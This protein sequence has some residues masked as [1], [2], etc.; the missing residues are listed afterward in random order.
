MRMFTI[1]YRMSLFLMIIGC[2]SM[3]VYAQTQ[4]DNQ[5]M[6][7]T[8]LEEEEKDSN[9]EEIRRGIR[10]GGEG[11][12]SRRQIYYERIIKNI[13]PGLVGDPHKLK[14]YTDY[15]VQTLINDT[16]LFATD[17]NPEWNPETNT[18]TLKGHVMF[19]E[20]ESAYLQYLKYLGFDNIESKLDVLPSENLG[21]LR[22]G[23]VNIPHVEAFDKPVE[24]R[25]NVTEALFGDPVFL[26]KKVEN[27]HY[28]CTT[29]E[30]YVGYISA[31]SIVP[32]NS[33]NLHRYTNGNKAAF[34]K[35]YHHPGESKLHIPS[36]SILKLVNYNADTQSYDIELP[37]SQII[38]IKDTDG[39]LLQVLDS[40]PSPFALEATRNAELKLE[41]D[42]E[43][44]GKTSEGVDCSGLVQSAYQSLGIYI[45]RDA[46]QQ[47]YNGKMVATRWYR[48]DLKPGD[49]LYFL[50]GTGKVTHTAIYVGD[51]QYV[52]ASGK[53]KYTSFNPDHENYSER[54][55]KGFCFAKRLFE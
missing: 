35:D 16:R 18:V 9:P 27:N 45:A 34:Q 22:Y 31:D 54:R 53:V 23:I 29:S 14:L 13:E 38:E 47:M 33:N 15:F 8:Q 50:G 40:D 30:G 12:K 3:T 28:L 2:S 48:E 41:T 11:G 4:E 26:L 1:A 42:Y 39:N 21:D 55:D 24:P 20:N 49:L 32:V 19:Q 44:G 17:I 43:W 7:N 5:P 51:D 46:S 36:G 37:T 6:Q 25:E 52:E 10:M